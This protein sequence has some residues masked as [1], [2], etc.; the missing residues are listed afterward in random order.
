[1]DNRLKQQLTQLQQYQ[2]QSEEWQNTL[3]QIVEL[4]LRSR[5]ICRPFKGQPLFGV[6]LEIYQR[7]QAQLAENIADNINNYNSAR[8]TPK[9]WVKSRQDNAFKIVLDNTQLQNLALEAQ[10]HPP[11]SELRQYALGELWQ[12]IQLSGRLYYPHQNSTSSKLDKF[13]YNEAISQTILY[14]CR[15]LNTY[16]PERSQFMTWMNHRLNWTLIDCKNKFINPNIQYLEPGVLDKVLPSE[17]STPLS[18]SIRQYIADDPENC[19]ASQHIKNRPD[20]NFRVIALARFA[21][22]T[23]EELSSNLD[24]KVSTLSRFFC[25]GCDK[26]HD[27]LLSLL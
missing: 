2:P 6:Y 15:H 4:T 27:Q 5:P 23:W 10:K 20:A 25:R 3:S 12:A 13:V 19:F 18:E 8:M 21:G 9:Q 11:R 14:L 22:K 24:I 17:D 7:V 1:M 26:F 16:N